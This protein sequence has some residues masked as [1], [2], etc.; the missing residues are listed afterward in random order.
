MH[1][2]FDSLMKIIQKIIL[3]FIFPFIAQPIAGGY[4]ALHNQISYTVSSEYFTRFK[5]NQFNLQD[6]SLNNRIK[7]AMVGYRASAWMG[8]YIGIFVGL[9]GLIQKLK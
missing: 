8:F 1:H 5:F 7:A 4:G 9:S 2:R 6:N 3:L